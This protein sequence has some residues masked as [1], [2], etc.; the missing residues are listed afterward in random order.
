[1]IPAGVDIGKCMRLQR[2]LRKGSI[3]EVLNRGLDISVIEANNRWGKRDRCIGVG[4]ELN[5]VVRYTHVDNVLEL[6]LI[7]S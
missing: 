1:M 7:Y 2:S 3:T 5:M 4:K 6:H